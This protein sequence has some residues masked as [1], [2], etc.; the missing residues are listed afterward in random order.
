MARL[1]EYIHTHE[2]THKDAAKRFHVSQPRINDIKRGKI[3]KFSIDCLLEMLMHEDFEA[4][5][6]PIK[7]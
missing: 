6:N 3:E 2:L 4:E 5:N 1:I 7:K